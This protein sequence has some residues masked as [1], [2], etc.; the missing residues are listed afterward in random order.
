MV[1][2]IKDNEILVHFYSS[3]LPWRT[4]CQENRGMYI[5][6]T[7]SQS[8]LKQMKEKNY[9][10]TAK[11]KIVNQK[12]KNSEQYESLKIY[13]RQY[14][15]RPRN[16]VNVHAIIVFFTIVNLNLNLFECSPKTLM[17]GYKNNIKAAHLLLNIRIQSDI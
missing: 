4:V 7:I 2:F 8:N 10:Q 14:L 17:Q 3:P 5:L 12:I 13:S 6:W 15:V 16:F 11:R 9:V 1:I